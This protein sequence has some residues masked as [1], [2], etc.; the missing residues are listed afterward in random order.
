MLRPLY[1]V[2]V[3]AFGGPALAAGSEKA[4]M[5]S[6]TPLARFRANNSSDPKSHLVKL[7][8]GQFHFVEGFYIASPSTPPGLPPGDG[9]LL[10][11][12]DGERGGVIVWT[13]GT[14]ACN[15]I[16]INE[17]LIML[18]SSIKSGKLEEMPE[19]PPA[20]EPQADNSTD[21]AKRNPDECS[22]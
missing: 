19:E 18:I 2:A 7:T 13:R 4:P 6:C 3:L 17:K 22:F 8:P 15:P 9:A 21:C 14:L 20:K 16:P 11:T 1:I 12:Y 10:A 5:P